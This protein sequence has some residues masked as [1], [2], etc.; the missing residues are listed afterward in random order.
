VE[1]PLKRHIDFPEPQKAPP[2][3]PLTQHKRSSPK[4]ERKPL[5]IISTAAL[6]DG[7]FDHSEEDQ[8]QQ[9]PNPQAEVSSF[10]YHDIGDDHEV[11]K[12]ARISAT[13]DEDQPIGGSIDEL[14]DFGDKPS[15]PPAD[16]RTTP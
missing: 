5:P 11:A 10:R 1:Q 9:L 4:P 12:L 13:Q 3:L 6:K 2:A 16:D 7:I 14:F 8:M 15:P